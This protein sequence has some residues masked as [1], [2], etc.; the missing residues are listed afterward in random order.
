[1]EK[2]ETLQDLFIEAKNS[3]TGLSE[4][5]RND[6]DYSVENSVVER[7]VEALDESALHNSIRSQIDSVQF[8]SELL[9]EFPNA[10]DYVLQASLASPSTSEQV[11]LSLIHRHPDWLSNGWWCLQRLSANPSCPAELID[12]VVEQIVLNEYFDMAE[13]LLDHPNLSASKRANLE[14]FL[15]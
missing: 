12:L 8:D 7:I 4:Y 2:A 5:I 13:H 1:L 10:K 15:S 6:F 14:S 11:L 3:L 9:A